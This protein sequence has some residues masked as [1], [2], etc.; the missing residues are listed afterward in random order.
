[1]KVLNVFEDEMFADALYDINYKKNV[2]NKKPHT[3]PKNDDVKLLMDECANIMNNIDIM[4][5]GD[6]FINVRAATA[7]YLIIFNARRGG[8]PVRLLISQWEEALRVNFKFLSLLLHK[9]C[10]YAVLIFV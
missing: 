4:D 2:T 7:T 9:A 8:E 1:M 10:C 3:L 6:E 5:F